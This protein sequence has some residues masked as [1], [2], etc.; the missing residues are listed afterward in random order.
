M[1]ESLIRIWNWNRPLSVRRRVLQKPL[2]GDLV[3][4]EAFIES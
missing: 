4:A 1:R 3:F 2:P